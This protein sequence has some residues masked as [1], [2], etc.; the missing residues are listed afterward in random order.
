MYVSLIMAV[1]A[2]GTA[3]LKV[4]VIDWYWRDQKLRRFSE[5]PEVYRAAIVSQPHTEMS[6]FYMYHSIGVAE[7]CS[8]LSLSHPQTDE[9]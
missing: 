8:A 1:D 5:V 6:T 9:N 2:L 3:E 4:V 7:L